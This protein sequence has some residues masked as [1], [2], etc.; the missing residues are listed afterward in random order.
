MYSTLYNAYIY[1]LLTYCSVVCNTFCNYQINDLEKMLY[2]F[3]KH[4]AIKFGNPIDFF[5]HD[6]SKISKFLNIQTLELSRFRAGIF[7]TYKLLS[8]IIDCEGLYSQFDFN[9]PPREFRCNRIFNLPL[10]K[11]GYTDSNRFL[12]SAHYVMKISILLI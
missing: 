9:V 3:L 2:I 11:N 10:V 6:W 8:V 4:A 5:S 12:D 1:P 7:L